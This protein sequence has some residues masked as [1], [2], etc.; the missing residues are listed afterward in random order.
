M[1]ILMGKFNRTFNFTEFLIIYP[2][3][4][5]L[6]L[7]ILNSSIHLLNFGV[8]LFL[9]DFA[10]LQLLAQFGFLAEL[11]HFIFLSSELRSLP[12]GSGPDL[13]VFML[14]LSLLSEHVSFL[15]LALS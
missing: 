12:L 13:L 14:L 3:F 1:E 2:E 10:L 7:L 11:L 4:T 5:N 8:V 6:T 15:Q 9:G